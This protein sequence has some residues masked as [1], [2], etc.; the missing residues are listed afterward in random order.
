MKYVL[1]ALVPL[2]VAGC[3][4]TEE[5]RSMDQ[6]K[7]SSFGYRPGTGRFADCM[8]K[9]SSQ[10]DDDDQRF[11]DRMNAQDRERKEA[12]RNRDDDIDTR[13]SYDKDGNPNFDTQGNYQGCQGIGCEVDNPDDDDN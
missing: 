1:L 6:E 12:R 11:L 3:V 9:Q 10:R 8:M 4:S 2:A 13:P 7:C 5:Q